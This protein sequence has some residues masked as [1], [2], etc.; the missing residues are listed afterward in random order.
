MKNV[1]QYCVEDN[2]NTKT[3]KDLFL[4]ATNT[5]RDNISKANIEE[6]NEVALQIEQIHTNY[7]LNIFARK[8]QI[9]VRLIQM[10]I[11]EYQ[12]IKKSKNLIDYDDI[13][14]QTKNHKFYGLKHRRA[15]Y[16]RDVLS[17]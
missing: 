14:I 16:D 10:I 8:N 12:K 1:H 13:I 6:L 2:F 9:F 11:D 7:L 5:V 3:F 17:K 4:T 15:C